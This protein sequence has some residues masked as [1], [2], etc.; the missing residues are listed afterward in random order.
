M[1][2]VKQRF[3]DRDDMISGVLDLQRASWAPMLSLHERSAALDIGAGY[4]A[5]THSLARSVGEVYSVEAI[6]ERIEFI[7]ERLRQSRVDNVQI[8]QASAT[9]LPLMGNSFDLAVANG[10]LEWIGEWDLEGTPR[11]AQLR[12]LQSV[13]RVLKPDGVLSVGIENRFGYG[14]FLGGKDH[15]GIAYTSLVPRSLATWM[16]RRNTEPHHRTQLNLRKEYRTYTYSERGYRKL[17][18]EAG[19]AAVSCFWAQPGYNQPYRLVPLSSP[20]WVREEFLESLDHPTL[21]ARQSWHRQ[22]KR[23]AAWSGVLP[24]VLPEFVFLAFKRPDRQR[25]V[26][27]WVG[28]RLS[29]LR[30]NTNGSQS[31]TKRTNWA[32][33]THPFRAK[34]VVRIGDVHSG[35]S[36]A[37]VKISVRGEDGIASFDREAI[38][39]AKVRSALQACGNHTIWIPET[40]GKLQLAN[41]SYCMESAAQGIQLSRITRQPEYFAH[42]S[43]VESD[44]VQLFER[45]MELTSALQNVSDM[46]AMHSKWPELP[47]ELVNDPELAAW[48]NDRRYFGNRSS[49]ECAKWIQHGDL[50][51]ENVFIDQ[52][53]GRIEVFDWDEL[54][55]GFPPLYDLFQLL[56]S[57]AYLSPTDEA[58][59]FESE[60]DRWVASFMAVFLGDTEFA[61]I[62]RRVIAT[63]CERLEIAPELVPSL[64]VEFLLVRTHFYA[65]NLAQ[66]RVHLQLLQML[67]QNDYAVPWELAR[68]RSR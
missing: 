65:E 67:A 30:I 51:V 35:S 49:S 53:R 2:A 10:V 45:L 9:A 43:R 7:Q 39:R 44:F 8:I 36:L 64:L 47:E 38:N 34:S 59:G 23:A 13:H 48:I 4:V 5:I 22:L 33:Y 24:L 55:A 52:K 66:R 12:F 21:R 26:D 32:L 68:E 31:K 3:G 29:E 14:L 25:E 19:F 58:V 54:A 57:T 17:F 61:G 56:F 18:S 62:A 41:T 50:S 60:V 46:P 11:Q 1:D 63:A 20:G 28:S 6:P 15:S 42:S 27:S 37:Y 40:Y 16:L